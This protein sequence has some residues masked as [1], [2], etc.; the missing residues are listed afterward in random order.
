M[1]L[2]DF[3][4]EESSITSMLP[5]ETYTIE[6]TTKTHNSDHLNYIFSSNMLTSSIYTIMW[7]FLHKIGFS[8]L[9][10]TAHCG[11]GPRSDFKVEGLGCELRKHNGGFGG[12]PQK[13]IWRPRPLECRKTLLHENQR[14]SNC[15]FAVERSLF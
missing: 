14:P 3:M 10:N 5:Q 9:Q 12:L 13:N 8:T 4:S 2:K 7:D 15:Q 6:K 11:Q 1:Y